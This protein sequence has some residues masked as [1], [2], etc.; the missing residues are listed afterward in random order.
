M[1]LFHLFLFHK[2]ITENIPTL[3]YITQKL[4]SEN[5]I[6]VSHYGITHTYTHYAHLQTNTHSYQKKWNQD[7][8]YEN[9]AS[10]TWKGTPEKVNKLH[11]HMCTHTHTQILKQVEPR[12]SSFNKSGFPWTNFSKLDQSPW[13]WGKQTTHSQTYTH[14]Q[15][16][17]QMELRVSPGWVRISSCFIKNTPSKQTPVTWNKTPEAEAK[18][19]K[20]KIRL[21][22]F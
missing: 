15:I 4:A 20:E 6:W 10:V 1:W 3:Q 18:K 14:P 11:I 5:Q 13:N 7:F 2:F 21:S 16:S 17:K 9:K 22:N 12:V 19:M 8:L